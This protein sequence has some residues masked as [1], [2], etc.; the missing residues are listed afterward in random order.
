VDRTEQAARAVYRARSRRRNARRI[1]DALRATYPDLPAPDLAR[2]VASPAFGEDQ[3]RLTERVAGVGSPRSDATWTLV[4]DRLAGAS[5][6]EARCPF[7][8]T[9]MPDGID[10]EHALPDGHDGPCVR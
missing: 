9:G 6:D 1:T 4:L 2:L 5:Y 8:R 7:C 3:H 10:G